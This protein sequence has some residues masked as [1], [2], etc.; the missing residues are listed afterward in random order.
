MVEEA[1]VGAEETERTGDV[2][3]GVWE[4]MGGG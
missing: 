3:K 1:C 4:D 2:V